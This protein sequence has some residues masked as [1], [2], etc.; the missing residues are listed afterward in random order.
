MNIPTDKASLFWVPM[1]FEAAQTAECQIQEMLNDITAF[2]S[3]NVLVKSPRSLPT[4]KG[5]TV[6]LQRRRQNTGELH[7]VEITSTSKDVVLKSKITKYYIMSVLRR[8]F[9]FSQLHD[10]ELEDMIDS[11]KKL[12]VGKEKV[13][14]L[15]GSYGDA[16]YILEEGQSHKNQY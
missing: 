13:I 1:I 7:D 9:L 8:H 11:M 16:F 12:M 14:I 6:D 3:S 15:E 4:V 5:H 2:Q 10:C